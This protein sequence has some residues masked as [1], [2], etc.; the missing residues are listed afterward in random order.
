MKEHDVVLN[1]IE[2]DIRMI[3]DMNNISTKL[4]DF[5]LIGFNHVINVKDRERSWKMVC[6]T[7]LISSLVIAGGSASLGVVV[8]LAYNNILSFG[9]CKDLLFMG[10]LS[11]ILYGGTTIMTRSQCMIGVHIIGVQYMIGMVVHRSSL[12]YCDL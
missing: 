4:N 7:S 11:D 8:F 9:F 3:A 10:G 5:G 1:L 2:R 12:A 6:V